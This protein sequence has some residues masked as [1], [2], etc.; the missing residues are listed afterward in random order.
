MSHQKTFT[1][2]VF[3]LYSVLGMG[4]EVLCATFEIIIENLKILLKIRHMDS[5]L[6]FQ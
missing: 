5:D 1:I 2:L 4:F 6:I 3:F